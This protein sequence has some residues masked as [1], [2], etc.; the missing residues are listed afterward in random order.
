MAEGGDLERVLVVDDD[1][2]LQ[3]MLRRTLAAEGFDVTVA[4]AAPRW[5]RPSG[6][7]PT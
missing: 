2:P 4:T 5:S 6:P 7:R 3:R 1:P